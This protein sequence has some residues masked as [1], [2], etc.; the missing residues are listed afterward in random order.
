MD[1]N[2]DMRS[3]KRVNGKT[4]VTENRVMNKRIEV[5]RGLSFNYGK[6]KSRSRFG[7]VIALIALIF[8]S[9]F[10]TYRW[11]RNNFSQGK[12]SELAGQSDVQVTEVL[13]LNE[14]I[15]DLVTSTGNGA[16]QYKSLLVA[17]VKDNHVIVYGE[18]MENAGREVILEFDNAQK[19]ST[20]GA[21]GVRLNVAL[22]PDKKTIAY[23]AN[24]GLGLYDLASKDKKILVKRDG[25]S[26]DKT[27]D[28]TRLSWSPDGHFLSL[29]Q[30]FPK[31]H[32]LCVVE[33]GVDDFFN[34]VQNSANEAL[35]GLN[36]QWA[37]SANLIIDPE[38]EA[39]NQAGIFISSADKFNVLDNLGKKIG[40][41]DV[42]F[43]EAAISEDSKTAVFTYKNEFAEIPSNILAISNI[44]GGDFVILDKE[45]IKTLPF[46][47]PGGRLVFFVTKAE[48]G[49]V[50]LMSIDSKTKKRKEVGNLPKGF[51][52]WSKPIWLDGRYLA[53]SG[54]SSA[55]ANENQNKKSIFLMLDIENKKLLVKK[56]LGSDVELIDFL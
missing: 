21:N 40:K 41:D 1:K 27:F 43:Y 39:G 44:D 3:A 33:V 17:S 15:W 7:M 54:I 55:P 48:N 42:D 31:Y 28:S 25:N 22:S 47:S 20:D 45:D 12:P 8:L 14:N 11:Q 46:F 16:P 23:M 56:E 29:V 52:L 34:P 53:I 32:R 26:A 13:G 4:A 2:F 51:D 30:I 49:S 19:I 36:A 50:A 35:A 38:A 5:S 6:R 24:D 18:N 9:S 10:V 37:P